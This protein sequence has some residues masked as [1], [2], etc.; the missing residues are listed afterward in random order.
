MKYVYQLGAILTVTFIGEALNRVIPLPIPASIYGL[1]I[2]FTA[3]KTGI[4]KL[5]H[6]K[7]TS[8]FLLE[9]MPILF[10]PA[11]VGLLSIWTQLAE[12][13]WPLAA[14]TLLT[15]LIVMVVTGKT[16]QFILDKGKREQQ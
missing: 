6:I 16:T 13:L 8:D 11:A 14:I 1:L 7:Q 5:K 3:L 4:L 15:T 9:M 10:V 12:F 2:M